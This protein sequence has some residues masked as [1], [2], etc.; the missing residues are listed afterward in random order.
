[1]SKIPTIWPIETHTLAKHGILEEYL[2]AWFP[3]LGR[4]NK[5]IVYL[6]G[7]AGPGIYT[8][9]EEGSPIIAIKTALNNPL[10]NTATEISFIFIDNNKKRTDVLKQ[11]LDEKFSSLPNNIKTQVITAEFAPTLS[12]TL[13]GLEQDG[14]NLAPTFAFI[15]PFGYAGFPMNLVTRLL[16]YSRCEVLITF[17]SG[18][19]NRFRDEIH[20]NTLDELFGTPNWRNS[21]K[22]TNTNQRI[23]SLLSL[24]VVQL[25]ERTG[26]GFIRTFR[27]TDEN[28]RT[29]Y[30]LIFATKHW[31]GMDAMKKAMFKVTKSGTYRFSDRSSP[32]QT[33]L[34]DY[35]DENVDLK[36]GGE[37]IYQNFKGTR[38]LSDLVR[39]FV[40]ARTPYILW[41]PFL[42][43]LEQQSPKK[44][45][46]VTGRKTK[47][48]TY[49]DGCFIQFAP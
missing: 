45:I 43:Y 36:R 31:K 7:F 12:S 20:E 5:R 41:R 47:A 16:N 48:L 10:V 38:V 1:M 19:V 34:M 49:K 42:K 4:W 25:H 13:D 14:K 32:G 27:M 44:I 17:M 35:F 18:F 8:G 37:L 23:D 28:D 40:L 30:E 2:K 9:G 39:D 24:Y 15:D 21:D 22:I 6:D 33:Y 11:T 26:A 29:L 3:I 46:G